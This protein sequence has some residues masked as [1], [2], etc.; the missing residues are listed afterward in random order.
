MPPKSG[1]KIPT[2]AKKAAAREPMKVT[3]VS[4]FLGSGKTSLLTHVLTNKEHK[5]K[6]AVIVNEISDFN[7]DALAVEGAHLLQSEE[8]MV[9]M[10]NGCIC[11]TL[12]ED[13]LQQLAELYRKG[14]DATLI[15]SSGI[16]EPMQVA[17]TFFFPMNG[18]P[19]G[20]TLQSIAP[21]DN[22]V[23]VVDAGTLLQH[24]NSI[25]STHLFDKS[26]RGTE[27]DRN[28]ATLMFDQLEFAN[29]IVLNKIDTIGNASAVEE[30]AKKGKQQPKGGKKNNGGATV[31]TL[32]A[33]I[34]R[35]NPTAK[36][37]PV[38]Y[39]KV[40]LKEILYTNNFTEKFAAGVSGWMDDVTTGLK[41][42]PE[43]EE[44]GVSSLSFTPK[45]PFHPQRLFDW[46]RKYFILDELVL[47]TQAQL[48]EKKATEP[49]L[50]AADSRKKEAAWAKDVN[51][52]SQR[53]LARYGNLFRGK[54]YAWIGQP[55]RWHVFATWGQAGNTLSFGGGGLWEQFPQSG[56]HEPVAVDPGQRLVFI[57]Q[58]LNKENLLADLKEL[59]LTTEEVKQLS[60]AMLRKLRK[61]EED[62]DRPD[63]FP[64][65]FGPFEL[66]ED[67]AHEEAEEEAPPAKK[68]RKEKN[69]K[70]K[71]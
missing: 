67:E 68:Q 66:R 3:L 39:S 63:V 52:R 31:E 71:K 16:A 21:L 69:G 50:S 11:C 18:K 44:Y 32:T 34:K 42:V 41:H 1:K 13:L 40:D 14:F 2:V 33:L 24:M 37:I 26:A 25:D 22:C 28:I 62:M 45:V 38:T 10:S 54:G 56:T 61:E 29:V 30:A 48:E 5:M 36:V 23:T 27:D 46:I 47:V 53:R 20:K 43:T 65:P 55:R 8:K 15:E 6:C 12:R 59:L 51:E 58:D 64:D 7:V 35:I 9:E 49:E 57:G 4:G 60:K 19:G 70:P 17:E